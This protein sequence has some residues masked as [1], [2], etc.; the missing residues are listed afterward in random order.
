MERQNKKGTQRN[1][2]P[3]INYRY[4]KKDNYTLPE[5]A[6]LFRMKEPM[7]LRY[8]D[9]SGHI[10]DFRR[11]NAT[12]VIDRDGLVKLHKKMYHA[13][14]N[15]ER[16]KKQEAQRAKREKEIER[17]REAKRI[18]EEIDEADRARVRE[19]LGRKKEI[20][21]M[22]TIVDTLIG[23][24]TIRYYNILTNKQAGK[25][26]D[27]ISCLDSFFTETKDDRRGKY[28][29]RSEYFAEQGIK[30]RVAKYGDSPWGLY[31][32]L[33]PTLLLGDNDRSALYR[34]NKENYEELLDRASKVLKKAKVPYELE[35]MLINRVDIT[36]NVI[37]K[38][39]EY[40]DGYIRIIKKSPILPCYEL[41]QFHKNEHKAKDPVKANKHSYIQ[42][43]KS[44]AYFIYNKRAQLLMID[45]FPE[46]LV[47]KYV[48]RFEAQL[49]GKAIKKWIS[50]DAWGNHYQVLQQGVKNGAT[51]HKWYLKRLGL[52]AGD[53][54]RYE[55]AVE[56]V[57]NVRSKKTRNRM[58]DIMEAL[59]YNKTNLT[60]VVKKLG[61]K[62]EAANK[63]M[64][65]FAKLGISPITVPNAED[66]TLPCLSEILDNPH[67]KIG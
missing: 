50:A 48:L 30:I 49:K 55:D 5:V 3:F 1:V 57:G 14:S 21:T 35:D 19:V 62:H 39:K 54:L 64:K 12:F 23:I 18:R 66:R 8:L 9:K 46:S 20:G 13:Y 31:I 36:M 45:K 6:A 29:Y 10:D 37:F 17:I 27:A 58:L 67:Y 4:L 24:D 33:H 32:L 26:L 59:G 61:L 47:D 60:N 2:L 22:K 42:R 28:S 7:L 44:A 51:I 65:T 43:C 52:L 38:Q 41:D 40:V 63:A 56:L 11:A 53:H 34:P 16:K 15:L 25:T